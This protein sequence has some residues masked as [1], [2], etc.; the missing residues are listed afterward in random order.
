MK[1][2][3]VV[4]EAHNT[5]YF[6][7]HEG[8]QYTIEVYENKHWRLLQVTNSLDIVLKTLTEGFRSS[9]LKSIEA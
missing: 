1:M 3:Q 2:K 4:I 6:V 5:K 8:S 7:T 9:A